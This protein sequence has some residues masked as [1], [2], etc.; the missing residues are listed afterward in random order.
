MQ[1][2][3]LTLSQGI[4]FFTHLPPSISALSTGKPKQPASTFTIKERQPGGHSGLAWPRRKR[5]W[6]PT[7]G[8]SAL[9]GHI[10]S[11]DNIIAHSDQSERSNDFKNILKKWP[12]NKVANSKRVMVILNQCWNFVFESGYARKG[13]HHQLC[14]CVRDHVTAARSM[15]NMDRSWVH[16]TD[17]S[18]HPQV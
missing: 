13:Q 4:Y 8:Q 18:L 11:K 15:W 9:C 1:S 12:K 7:P 14:R 10:Q 3:I 6:P 2:K 16:G 5:V 17:A